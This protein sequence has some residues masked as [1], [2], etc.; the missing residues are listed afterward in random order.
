LSAEFLFCLSANATFEAVIRAIWFGK[1]GGIV[2]TNEVRV[3]APV[4]EDEYLIKRI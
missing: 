2:P 3:I 4:N 1:N